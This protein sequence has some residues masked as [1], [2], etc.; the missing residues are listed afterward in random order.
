MTRG[1]IELSNINRYNDGFEIP[2]T[3]LNTTIKKA[4]DKWLK[5]LEAFE[6]L[7][8]FVDGNFQTEF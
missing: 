4:T 8:N 6:D 3:K 7:C 5:K 2:E 1:N